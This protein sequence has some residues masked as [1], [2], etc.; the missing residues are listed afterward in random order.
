MPTNTDAAVECRERALTFDESGEV[1][2]GP[3]YAVRTVAAIGSAIVR[4]NHTPVA[5]EGSRP[6]PH[7]HLRLRWCHSQPGDLRQLNGG[8]PAC[9]DPTRRSHRMEAT[10]SRGEGTHHIDDHVGGRRREDACFSGG[11]RRDGHTSGGAPDLVVDVRRRRASTAREHG[12]VAGNAAARRRHA[13]DRGD[14]VHGHDLADVD[15]D[16]AASTQTCPMRHRAP[17]RECRAH[18]SVSGTKPD[19]S[20]VGAPVIDTPLSGAPVSAGVARHLPMPSA[21]R[22]QS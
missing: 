8:N 9:V 6:A 3:G 17:G 21:R 10:A 15:R 1:P 4:F 12:E 7:R 14:R 22:G 18:A 20:R 11:H 5:S 2:H 16:G 19:E 13:E